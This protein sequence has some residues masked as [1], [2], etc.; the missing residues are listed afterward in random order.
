[1]DASRF[2]TLARSLGAPRSRRG[3][4][5]TLTGTV[6]TAALGLTNGRNQNIHVLP[7]VMQFEVILSSKAGADNIPA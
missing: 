1:M 2:D 6:L 5:A 7:E 3:L 4:L